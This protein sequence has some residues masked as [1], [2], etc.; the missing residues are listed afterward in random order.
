M[1][2]LGDIAARKDAWD[3]GFLAVF[4]RDLL[5]HLGFDQ[6]ATRR[7]GQRAG[8][9]GAAGG[10][11]AGKGKEPAI[12]QLDIGVATQSRDRGVFDGDTAPRQIIALFGIKADRAIGQECHR[13]PFRQELRLMD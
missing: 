5:A 11:E 8:G 9:R 4:C 2:G 3:A 13:T 10:E 12:V 6:F 1:R 7:L